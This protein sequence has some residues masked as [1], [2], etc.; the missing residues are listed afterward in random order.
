MCIYKGNEKL[1]LEEEDEVEV[2]DLELDDGFD[3]SS[4]IE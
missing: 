4:S 3:I 1:C 2:I